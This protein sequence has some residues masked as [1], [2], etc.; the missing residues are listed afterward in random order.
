MGTAVRHE[1]MPCAQRRVDF[2]RISFVH[3]LIGPASK[4]TT[5]ET[6]DERHCA[7]RT[8]EPAIGLRVLRDYSVHGPDAASRRS[9]DVEMPGEPEMTPPETISTWIQDA[10]DRGMPEPE[11]MSLATAT[12]AGVPS[13]RIVL[14]RGIDARGLRFFTNY[15]SRKGAELQLNAY[16][17]V[18]FHWPVLGRQARVEGAAE[19]LSASESDAYFKARPRGHQLSAW[20]SAQSRPLASQDALRR[21]MEELTAQYEGRDVPRPPYWGG[22]LLRPTAVELWT[23][24]ADRIHDRVRFELVSGAWTQTR[25]GP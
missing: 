9:R 4:S 5:K 11:A 12:P 10:R 22:F 13:V 18:A 2:L 16:A 8:P 15:E 3:R 25:L 20:A 24:G 21:R 17:A 6:R 14:C 23:Q 1:H 7:D 19:R